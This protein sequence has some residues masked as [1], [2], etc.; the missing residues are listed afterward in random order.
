MTTTQ[1]FESAIKTFLS[2][3]VLLPLAE[4]AVENRDADVSRL[5]ELFTEK[6]NL[7]VTVPQAKGPTRKRSPKSASPKAEQQWLNYDQYSER[8]DNE[9]LCGYVQTRGKFKDH[10]CGVVL[11]NTNVVSWSKDNN[12]T[13]STPEKELEEVDGKRGE[14][15]CKLCWARDPKTGEYKR[16]KGRGGKLVS[17]H[18]GDIVAPTV[19][20]GVSVPDNE[21][22]MGFLSGN[23]KSFVSPTRAMEPAKKVIRAKRFKGL[24][25]ND[26]YSH[27]MPN[28][29]HHDMPWLI[30][31]DSEGQVVI[32]KFEKQPTPSKVFD[33]NYL[34]DLLPLD[35]DEIEMCKEYNLKYV[36]HVVEEADDDIDIPVVHEPEEDTTTIQDDI[37]DVPTLEIDDMLSNLNI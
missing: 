33:D 31:A 12:F 22:L 21:S 34:E 3:S 16:K 28:P 10:Y 11:D 8:C 13:E 30:R 5:I 37:P 1:A 24:A 35:E 14:M 18:K 27:V 17:E 32:G 9:Y 2:E 15:R 29:E 23:S 7:P 19:I 6:L 25:R 20:P 36:Q 4:T 26:T